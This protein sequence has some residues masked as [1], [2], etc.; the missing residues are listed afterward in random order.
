M[1]TLACYNVIFALL[2][3]I[4]VGVFE[5]DVEDSTLIAVP[6]QYKVGRRSELYSY[7]SIFLILKGKKQDKA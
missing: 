6:Q 5:K 3:V 4:F 1:W 2:P 7:K